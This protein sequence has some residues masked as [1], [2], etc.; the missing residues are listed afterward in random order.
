VVVS[1]DNLKNSKPMKNGQD[2][3]CV[4][5]KNIEMLKKNNVLFSI[6]SVLDITKTTN[7]SNS[8]KYITENK[9]QWKMVI[10]TNFNFKDKVDDAIK[11][12][13]N[14]LDILKEEKY[15]KHYVDFCGICPMN[16]RNFFICGCGENLLSIN[17]NLD[18]TICNGLNNAVLGKFDVN[19]DEIIKNSKRNE[20]FYKDTIMQ[21]CYD[22]FLLQ[23]CYGGCKIFHETSIAFNTCRMKN[24]RRRAAGY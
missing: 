20:Y 7:G 13:K 5:F 11:I 2:S 21:K 4:V 16:D 15:P 9:V 12:F 3:A 19:L 18:L 22:C 14:A 1:L 8:A 17:P 23:K 10:P 6:I 24:P